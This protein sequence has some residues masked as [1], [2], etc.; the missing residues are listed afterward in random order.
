ML[1]RMLEV[2]HAKHLLK[3][4][5]MILRILVDEVPQSVV[6]RLVIRFLFSFSFFLQD[7]IP[8]PL[9]LIHTHTENQI[10]MMSFQVK[11]I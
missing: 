9:S 5:H 8:T 10:D 11:M 1:K 2:R 3:L 4:P 7:E 6:N